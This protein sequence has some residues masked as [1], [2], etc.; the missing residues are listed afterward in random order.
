MVVPFIHFTTISRL[1]SQ[2]AGQKDNREEKPQQ[3]E[4]RRADGAIRGVFV[5]CGFMWH[6]SVGGGL[7]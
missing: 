2:S 5:G 3:S 1:N 7:R 4:E 6:L